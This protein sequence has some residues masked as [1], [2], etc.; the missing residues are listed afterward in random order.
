MLLYGFTAHISSLNQLHMK[1]NVLLGL[2]LLFIAGTA[3]AQI[4]KGTKL[5]GGNVGISFYK[6]HDEPST[7][8]FNITL[9]P[10]I[11]FTFKDNQVYGFNVTYG[12]SQTKSSSG[13]N[14]SDIYGGGVFYRRYL[15]LGKGFYL[16]GQTNAGYTLLD[17]AQ[18]SHTNFNG[19]KRREHNVSIGLYP[20]VSFAVNHRI[21]VELSMNNLASLNYNTTTTKNYGPGFHSEMKTSG[22]NLNTNANPESELSVG[23]R[24]ALGKK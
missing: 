8:N 5:L 20:G 14:E 15:T 19:Y 6:T 7:R 23:F 2:T 12:R 18:Y 16:F 11:G 17:A 1:R 21:H 4:T 24:I 9:N 3:N 22:F 10:S 13:W